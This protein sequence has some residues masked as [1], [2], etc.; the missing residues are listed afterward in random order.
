MIHTEND[1]TGCDAGMATREEVARLA[2]VSVATVS[3]VVNGTKY[4][5]PELERRVREA[6]SALDYVPNMAARSMVTKRSNHIA[7]LANDLKNPRYA[8]IAE[9][10]QQ[11]AAKLGYIVSVINYTSF[12]VSRE[13]FSN[14]LSRNIDGLFVATYFDELDELLQHAA[15]RGVKVIAAGKRYSAV[16]NTDYQQATHQ[17][18][19]DLAGL[20]HRRI[21]FISGFSV[22]ES[23]HAKFQHYQEALL[24]H[25]LEYDPG[26]VRDGR[27]PYAATLQ[28][29]YDGMNEL[30]D[31][32]LA[33]TAVYAL[34]DL[35]A[36]GALRALTERGL[37]VPQDISLVGCDNVELSRF[38]SPPLATID[39]PK[40]DM[41]RIAMEMLSKLL[42]GRL[43]EDVWIN[44]TYIRRAS[45]GPAP[46]V[47]ATV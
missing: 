31:R 46:A 42:S 23:H 28:V 10:M 17:M 22:N 18:V 12:D 14:L 16:L 6:I 19:R 34:N 25:G 36:A 29:G 11:I 30:L 9:V 24:A 1:W 7:V 5:S 3:H 43:C 38:C 35:V 8:A 15:D 44:S 45:V 47:A 32:G 4:V 26:L 39:V 37:R 2:K 33:M 13:Q 21:G 41:G 20:G 40:E 27:R